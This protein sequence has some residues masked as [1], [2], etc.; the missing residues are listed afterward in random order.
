[1]ANQPIELH[2]DLEFILENLPANIPHPPRIDFRH[3]NIR[4]IM[5]RIHDMNVLLDEE[6]EIFEFLGGLKLSKNAIPRYIEIEEKS[7]KF[8]QKEIRDERDEL[9]A[10]CVGEIALMQDWLQR[11]QQAEVEAEENANNDSVNNNA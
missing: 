5:K 6:K 1:M 8:V 9:K 2:N 7:L 3:I 4:E 11:L 10:I